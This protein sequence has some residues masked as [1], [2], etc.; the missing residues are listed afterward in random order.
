MQTDKTLNI[1]FD[2]GKASYED[3]PVHYLE[4]I[5]RYTANR[6]A[7]VQLFIH[8]PFLLHQTYCV[9]LTRNLI[10]YIDLLRQL[11]RSFHQIYSSGLKLLFRDISDPLSTRL[12]VSTNTLSTHLPHYTLLE[13]PTKVQ[14]NIE[15]TPF[16]HIQENVFSMVPEWSVSGVSDKFLICPTQKQSL[17][18]DPIHGPRHEISYNQTSYSTISPKPITTKPIQSGS[19]SATFPLLP[20]GAKARFQFKTT[21][22][23]RKIKPNTNTSSV[24]Q[25]LYKKQHDAWTRNATV[26]MLLSPVA[27]KIGLYGLERI[28]PKVYPDERMYEKPRDD[29]EVQHPIASQCNLNANTNQP[30]LPTFL[31]TSTRDIIYKFSNKA[32]LYT[33]P[34][35]PNRKKVELRSKSPV[36][37]YQYQT[38]SPIR[39]IQ[40][41]RE[42]YYQSV[43]YCILDAGTRAWIR[44]S[45]SNPFGPIMILIVSCK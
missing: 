12:P 23:I 29:A 28:A 41:C 22:K 45:Q 30:G 33:S 2:K 17:I 31:T 16:N 24:L 38:M 1:M 8:S 6:I 13:T 27:W 18:S 36:L 19:N 32:R 11:F 21:R 10:L 39:G 25:F 14:W 40:G 20:F 15:A 7:C 35:Q 42:Q 26:S 43:L 5:A 9:S 4:S 3:D 37:L 44:T 34:W